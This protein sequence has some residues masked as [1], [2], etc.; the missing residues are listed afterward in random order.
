MTDT[1]PPLPYTAGTLHA[2]IMNLPADGP[3]LVG[4]H[5]D[6]TQTAYRLGHRDA[7]H[8][9][10]ELVIAAAP[11]SAQTALMAQ[12]EVLI[13]DFEDAVRF[14][15]DTGADDLRAALLAWIAA[16]TKG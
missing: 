6:C 7:R 9:A 12:A 5:A 11:E 13:A 2:A 1:L 15:D 14:E 8:A 10:A 3:G 4:W 16:N